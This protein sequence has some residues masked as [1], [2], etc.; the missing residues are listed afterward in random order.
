MSRSDSKIIRRGPGKL[1]LTGFL[2]VATAATVVSCPAVS[3][4][5][6][7][8]PAEAATF[9]QASAA[10]R[11]G[12]KP[13]EVLEARTE[14][15]Q[16]FAAPDGSFTY[17]EHMVPQRARRANGTWA[18][19]DTK[20]RRNP[21]GTVSPGATTMDVAFS[22]G[23]DKTPM[24]TMNRNGKAMKLWWPGSLPAP[25]LK[26][27]V[28]TY[29][30]VLAGVDLQITANADSFVH[31]I[32][33]KNSAAAANPALASLR[34]RTGLEGVSIRHGD[35]DRL[36]AV[37]SGGEPVF[38]GASAVMWDS[39]GKPGDGRVEPRQAKVGVQVAADALTLVPDAAMLRDPNAVFPLHIDPVWQEA[40]GTRS[41]H[42]VLRKSFPDQKN[43]DKTSGLGSNDDT[44]GVL[45]AG[46]NFDS[47]GTYTDRSL[48]QMNIGAV[49]YARINSAKFRL[50]HSWSGAGCGSN[51]Q[52]LWTN[53]HSVQP[54][55]ANTSWNTAWNKGGTGWGAILA[56]S[57][58]VRR[59]GD[60]CGYGTVEFNVTAK[61][62]ER[63]AAGDAN[64]W[65]GL[66]SASESDTRY[67]RRYRPDAVIQIQ[68]NNAPNA[69]VPPAASA[70]DGK[71]CVT[72]DARP[73][74]TVD[75]PALAVSHSDP[76][77]AQATLTTD[78]YW[79]ES[80][81]SRSETN[82]V[83][84]TWA[85]GTSESQA[86]PAGRLADGK[87]YF[88]QA[89][90][91]DGI[92]YGQF[93]AVCEFSVDLTKPDTPATPQAAKYNGSTPTGGPGIPDTFTLLPP[94][95][96]PAEVV[97]YAYSFDPGATAASAIQVNTV[98]AQYR[99][100]LIIAPPDH[101]SQ[102]LRVWAKDRAGR[103]SAAPATFT[104]LVSPGGLAA[105]WA[106]E[107]TAPGTDTAAKDP[108]SGNPLNLNPI[109]VSGVTMTDGRSH[110]TAAPN[111]ALPLSGSYAAEATGPLK[112]KSG[113]VQT[114][115]STANSFTVAAWVKLSSAG[116]TPQAALALNG[117]NTAGVMLG[118]A[119]TGQKWVF[120]M[121]DTDTAAPAASALHAA[122]SDAVAVAGR[123][124]HLAG[125]YDPVTKRLT[126]YVNGIAQATTSVLT[127]GF[128]ATG[129]V[130]AGAQLWDGATY[131]R[132]LTG[133]VDG[134]QVYNTRLDAA[135]IQLLARPVAP[136]V[137]VLTAAPYTPGQAVQ[138]K[139]DANGDPNVTAFAY[140]AGSAILD[141]AASPVNATATVTITP[142]APGLLNIFGI[143]KTG[144]V[145]S[146]VASTT[147]TVG[148]KPSLQG[149][150]IGTS[151]TGIGQATVSLEPGG[152]QAT[153]DAS[154]FF[155]FT[156][157]STGG[158]VLSAT[159]GSVCGLSGST[160]LQITRDL[161]HN[162][163][164]QPTVTDSFGYA[165]SAVAGSTYVTADNQITLSGDNAVARIDLPFT[166]QY[167]GEAVSALWADT[168]GVAYT[169]D[170]GTS[171]AQPVAIPGRS[172]PNGLIAPYWADLVL[173]PEYA[174]VFTKTVGSAPNRQFVVEWRYAALA[175]S[176]E[177]WFGFE[178]IVGE[179]GDIT[180][181]YNDVDTEAE[182][183]G[184]AV[185]GIENR[186]G[187][188]GI[189]YSAFTPVINPA[190]AVT[191]T[192][193]EVPDQPATY[194]ISGTVT[195]AGITAVGATV[196]LDPLGLSAVTDAQ[197]K[198]RFDGLPAGDYHV[199]GQL[200]RSSQAADITLA[201]DTVQNF[202]LTQAA[203]SFGYTCTI[204][205]AAFVPADQTVLGLS[206]D[207]VSTQV[208][209]PFPFPFYGQNVTSA[210][211]ATNGY[212]TLLPWDTD[213]GNNES[214]PIPSTEGPE[215]LIAPFWDD[216]V[217]DA[218]A[219]VRT[220]V[221]GTAPDR[222]FVIEWR[223]VTHFNDNTVRLSF[224]V[225]LGENGSIMFSYDGIDPA[226]PDKERG[227][228]ATVGL[229][230]FAGNSG[231]VVS[232][233]EPVL[234]TGESVKFSYPSTVAQAN[235]SISGTATVGGSVPA[236]G[237]L[238]KLGPEVRFALTDA[239]GNYSFTGLYPGG[240]TVTA[241]YCGQAGTANVTA[242]AGTIAPA[243]SVPAVSGAYGCSESVQSFVTG[244]TVL[245]LTGDDAIKE[246]TT[247]F[248][249][250]L[251]GQQTST[252][253]VST[254]GVI[255]TIA[256]SQ[257]NIQQTHQLPGDV[258]PNG[259]IAP[260]WED[261]VIDEQSQVLTKT[262]GSGPNRQFVVEWRDAEF[263]GIED[264][265]S[266]S[267]VFSENG[268]ITFHYEG[269][270][271][272]RERGANATVGLENS[273][274]TA[275]FTFSHKQPILTSG[276][277]IVLTPQA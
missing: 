109:Q 119:G 191:F 179:N 91:Y 75:N 9:A 207:D 157:L 248:P 260:F 38:R 14:T 30:E 69:P 241:H 76:N 149:R 59:Y 63:A 220:T 273:T 7:G 54:F 168:N 1:A 70:T 249:I 65:L 90:T 32:V 98:D 88:W 192:Y 224:E 166:V 55:D 269:Q 115:I 212:L 27:N 206:G 175:S 225:V 271:S 228:S 143:S 15:A 22:G 53:L 50:T 234:V 181:R 239:Q 131:R 8:R 219:S 39:S 101:G 264:R 16:V 35:G 170:P 113:G 48:F 105:S 253:H 41:H 6:D 116:S 86:I 118:Y 263:F 129:K 47:S 222:Q 237:I 151:G 252:L 246:I 66:K 73:W 106:F 120:Q 173:N 134:V 201:A 62:A 49:K 127:T 232:F 162:L 163:E 150:V 117:T 275:G 189:G 190:T 68:Y 167:Y 174:G 262:T 89:R 99:A 5:A 67:W 132:H 78:F 196:T 242:A 104:F 121:A 138:V 40:T 24:A 244:D 259:L 137:T 267:V 108:A 176:P 266:F 205:Q 245:D 194:S 200:C 94:A 51:G 243:I 96:K 178:A 126:L 185:V 92:D 238:V 160:E 250:T 57:D 10:A 144:T 72:G 81:G 152:H 145:D 247:P 177:N 133:A 102:T 180:F 165:C 122:T 45:R 276:R 182:T 43:Y 203:D 25:V 251:Y 80:T 100:V 23:G 211:V 77:S 124:T 87:T 112:V 217:V 186:Y 34:L 44:K 95:A 21:N 169:R 258:A 216:L 58:A 46:Y 255:S 4:A 135:K 156:G 197:G 147:I 56:Q 123:W 136:T 155:S 268:Q 198:Y 270:A 204:E 37:D 227:A 12:R 210:S 214:G 11:Q 199:I 140:S 235:A 83:S 110:T 84:K 28:A 208:Q 226:G 274:G 261:L 26:D 265:I 36:E 154:G 146:E 230:N 231:R 42:T 139:L 141:K 19:I 107:G 187:S 3:L 218:Q 31:V 221:T 240:Y 158:Y 164:L 254:N 20:L 193:P 229:E 272:T 79:W 2:A 223:N 161:V 114:S 13:V 64:L 74:V 148:S 188:T 172:A 71:P 184:S 111:K 128:N 213:Y 153:S 233:G 256:G 97:G 171:S 159:A 130:S 29:P 52:K 209:L 236:P 277:A 195:A 60:T 17:T 93:S 103:T 215:A 142:Q 257:L 183:G 85:R 202:A 82:K 61:T 33:V 18:D 125:T